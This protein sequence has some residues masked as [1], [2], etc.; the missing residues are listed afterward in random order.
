MRLHFMA[1]IEKAMAGYSAKRLDKIYEEAMSAEKRLVYP[2][3]DIAIRAEFFI[4][5]CGYGNHDGYDVANQLYHA[6][7]GIRMKYYTEE[8]LINAVK[9]RLQQRKIAVGC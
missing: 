4:L 8:E 6:Y 2:E 1:G 3:C 5:A 7:D 9:K